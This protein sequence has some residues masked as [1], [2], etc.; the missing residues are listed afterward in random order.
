MFCWLQLR[1]RTQIAAQS[2]NVLILLQEDCL[3]KDWLKGSI[4]LDAC[5][6]PTTDLAF[7]ICTEKEEVAKDVVAGANEAAQ[8]KV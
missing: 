3:L 1:Q 2:L 5:S 7:S 8:Q 6:E 4:K